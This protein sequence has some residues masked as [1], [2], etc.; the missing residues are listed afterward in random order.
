METKKRKYYYTENSNKRSQRWQAENMTQIAIRYNNINDA[1][2]L[3]KL[4]EV[5]NKADYIRQLIRADIKRTKDAE[6]IKSHINN[7]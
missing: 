6:F 1:D 4:N 2:I 3:E 5:P 7:L